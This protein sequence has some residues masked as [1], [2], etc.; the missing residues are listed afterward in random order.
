MEIRTI[1]HTPAETGDLGA[2]LAAYLHPGDV[3]N[4][5]GDL[6]AG[7]TRFVQG[8]AAELGV[9]EHVTSPTFAIIKEYRGALLPL[10]H[11]D[12]YRLESARELADL[13]YE[14]YWFGDGATVIEWGDKFKDLLPAN[15]LTIE[16]K[17]GDAT[18][19]RD[20]SFVFK[21]IRWQAVV[22]AML[23]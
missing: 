12:V 18:D 19:Q 4:L 10:Y 1:S 5:S 14:D 23:R 7:K 8:L 17:R 6:G 2:R 22:E 16:F 15:A 13:G 20:L 11:F 21:D 3:I 9:T